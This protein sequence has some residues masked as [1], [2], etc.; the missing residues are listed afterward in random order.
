MSKFFIDLVIYG[1]NPV[2]LFWQA[3]VA[4]N[5]IENFS[6]LLF[7]YFVVLQSRIFFDRKNKQNPIMKYAMGASAL[8]SLTIVLRILYVV[9]SWF[10]TNKKPSFWG[11]LVWDKYMLLIFHIF[12]TQ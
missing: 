12:Y 4:W 1:L 9:Y 7:I 11:F 8:A 10:N 2:L 5:N 6:F 3:Y